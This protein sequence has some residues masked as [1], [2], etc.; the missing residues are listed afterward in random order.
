MFAQSI[1][2]ISEQCVLMAI[3]VKFIIGLIFLQDFYDFFLILHVVPQLINRQDLITC[4]LE[5]VLQE[6]AV[7]RDQSFNLLN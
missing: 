5:F 3:A 7:N 6:V 4:P 1:D 2:F